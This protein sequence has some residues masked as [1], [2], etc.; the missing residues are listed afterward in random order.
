M[1]LITGGGGFVGTAVRRVLPDA[2][3]PTSRELDLTDGSAV[4]DVIAEMKPEVVVHLA[5]RVGGITANMARQADFL[6]DNLRM[7]AN[8]LAALR[9]HPPRH[10]ISMLST[11][12]YPDRLPDDDYPMG[13]Q[14]IEAGP[15][16]PTN[17]AYAAAKRSLWR[18]TLA[19]N[20]QYGVPYTALVPANLYGPGDHFGEDGSHFLAAAIDKIERASTDS[21]DAVEFFGT[22]RAIRQYVYVEDVARLI[23]HIVETGSADTTLNVA[24][25]R[26]ASIRELAELVADV[27]GYEGEIVFPGGGPDGQLLKDVDT[28]RLRSRY[29]IWDEIETPLRDGI[30]KTIDHYRDRDVESG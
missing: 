3:A 29:P 14:L 7:D 5:A 25:T 30:A 2:A 28:T 9:A 8:L 21:S 19:L 15:P 23:G 22:G 12:M 4:T 1:L 24:P 18:G 10:L 26:S 6:I 16:P 17:A 11:C 13:E 27:A 20:D